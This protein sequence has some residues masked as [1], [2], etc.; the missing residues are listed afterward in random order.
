MRRRTDGPAVNA[1]RTMP[2]TGMP[3][4]TPRRRGHLVVFDGGKD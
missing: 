1:V 2:A 3:P 4:A